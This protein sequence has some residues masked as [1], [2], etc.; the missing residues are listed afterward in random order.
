MI[1]LVELARIESE[2]LRL[3]V[4]DLHQ[5]EI[6]GDIEAQDLQ[7]AMV[8]GRGEIF[9]PVETGLEHVLRDDVIVGDREI[10]LDQEGRAERRLA[11][12]RRELGADLQKLAARGFENALRG[13]G[14]RGR[15]CVSVL[16]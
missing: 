16:C 1:E 12:A 15:A 8:V 6:V 14:D 7:A 5:R 11:A 3:R 10:A 4:I 2:M 13:R 9:E